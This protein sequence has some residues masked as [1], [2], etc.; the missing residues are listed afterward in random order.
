MENK[1]RMLYVLVN[2]V[3]KDLEE[4]FNP[5]KDL[6]YDIQLLKL[7]KLHK[8]L[9]ENNII[10]YGI[11]TDCLLVREDKIT[12]GIFINFD[13]NIG[14]VKF[15]AGKIPI[16]RRIIMSNNDLIEFKQ[17]VVN[18]IKLNDEYDVNEM[19][20]KLHQYDRVYIKGLLPG[21]GKTTGA[22]NSGYKLEFVTPYNKLC[23]ELRK[24]NYNS[25]TLNKL[26]NIN[27]IGEYNKK[28]KQHDISQYEAICFDEIPMYGPHYLSKIYNFMTKTDRKIFATGDVD[29]LKPIGFELNN[30]TDVKEY[31]NRIL[32]IMFPNQII[33]EYN[34]RLKTYE[35][36]L[37][38]KQ[39]KEDIFNTKIGVSTT[40][41]KIF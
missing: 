10:V 30:V 41:K 6:I 12:L 13:N 32:D 35:D 29:Q 20:N 7:W 21:T 38:L 26:L 1:E 28:A 24:E 9:T 2:S 8:Q 37:K 34:K 36:Q 17:P 14:G 3:K 16:K 11:K 25:V 27:I 4:S 23:Q 15:E 40:M 19:K 39:I 22:K 33:L 31:M 18:I 5:I